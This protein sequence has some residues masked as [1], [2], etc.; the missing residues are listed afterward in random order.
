METNMMLVDF[1]KYC[2]RCKYAPISEAEDPCRDCLN[3]GTNENS[4]R[5]VR[6]KKSK[7]IKDDE[8]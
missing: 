7:T 2:N 3:Y 5:P 6:Y 8:P 4:T 1:A